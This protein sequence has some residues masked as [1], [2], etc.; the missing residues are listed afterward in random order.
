MVKRESS[1]MLLGIQFQDDLKWKTQIFGKGGV[2]SSL[3][4]RLYILRRMRN[5]LSKQAILK[6]VDGIFVSKIRYGLQLLGKVR[7]T[8]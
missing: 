3:N 1:A 8:D 5:H 2:L 7:L 4:S 6:M